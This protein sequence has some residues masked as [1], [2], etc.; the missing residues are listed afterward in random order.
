MDAA[1]RHAL[2]FGLELQK[3]LLARGIGSADLT[4]M[5]LRIG[6]HP[7]QPL[8]ALL[9]NKFMPSI[10]LINNIARVMNCSPHERHQLHVTAAIDR[11]YDI[12]PPPP[13]TT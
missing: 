6:V 11:G 12:T 10:G 1:K 7:E 5:L 8:D 9:M 2:S 13:V 4:R 3:L